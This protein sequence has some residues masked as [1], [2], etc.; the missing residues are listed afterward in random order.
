MNTGVG[1]HTL[2]QKIF[3]TMGSN[4]S[5]EAP[6]LQVDSL[7]MN[8]LG[9]PTNDAKWSQNDTYFEYDRSRLFQTF[10]YGSLL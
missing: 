9:T 6:A 2:L 4:L 3:P 8:H 1:F 7:P 10:S 5:P